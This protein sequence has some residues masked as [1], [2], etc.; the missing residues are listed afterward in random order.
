MR[1]LIENFLEQR[2][3]VV[4]VLVVLFLGGYS[5]F[6]IS[7]VDT[8]TI[9]EISKV[10]RT[11]KGGYR[12]IYKYH[13]PEKGKTLEGIYKALLSP[14]AKKVA[15]GEKFLV[16]YSAQEPEYSYIL[17]NAIAEEKTNLDS[18]NNCCSP[19]DFISF[20]DSLGQ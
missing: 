4:I 13:I 12:C 15:I 20:F 6:R 5:Y 9:G 2:Y 3:Y 18:L 10:Y 19:Q 7:K 1:K 8:F 17:L 14:K 16:G 11:S